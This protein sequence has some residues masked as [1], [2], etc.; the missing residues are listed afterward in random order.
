MDDRATDPIHYSTQ[1]GIMT[2]KSR[3]NLANLTFAPLIGQ[4][5]VVQRLTQAVMQQR[6][7]PAYLFV[8]P[9]GVGR[10][11]AAHCFSELLCCL[12][13]TSDDPGGEFNQAKVTLVQQ[14]IQQG[15]HPD[16]LWVE[17]TYQVQGK[18][19]PVRQAIAEGLKPKSPP[20]IRLNQIRDIAE[21]LSRAPLEAPRNLVILDG[22]E[23][24]AEAAANGLLKTLEEPGQA[25]LILIAPT[26]ES[27][28][29]TLISRCQR[30]PFVRLMPAEMTRILT[31]LN[32]TDLLEQPELLE[33]AQGSPGDAIACW[34]YLQALPQEL[35]A[36]A[37]QPPKTPRS[38]LTFARQIVQDLDLEQQLWFINYLQQCYWQPAQLTSCHLLKQLE[39]AKILL[40]RS[41]QPR[42]VWE[43]TLLKLLA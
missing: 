4:A 24:M 17:P 1:I 41:V 22:A 42:L 10:R 3:L 25:T 37:Q 13:Y 18:S 5:P 43:V 39:S 34:N 23:T 27:L 19:V 29:P 7:A 30:I 6:I 9:A 40:Q 35:V 8:G 33:M 26:V 16:I 11:L 15:N 20:Q 31:R 36:M 32:A 12:P 14:R 2:P 38:A 21:F 28:L